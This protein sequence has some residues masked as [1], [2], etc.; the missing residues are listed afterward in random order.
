MDRFPARSF[1]KEHRS[2]LTTDMIHL[3]RP[4]GVDIDGAVHVQPDAAAAA[5]AAATSGGGGAAY[6]A[7]G[8]L[9]NPR[10]STLTAAD[11]HNALAKDAASG[12]RTLLRVPLYYAGLSPGATVEVEWVVSV[13]A[14]DGLSVD[15]ARLA[16]KGRV[17]GGEGKLKLKLNDRSELLLPFPG[18]G[19]RPHSFAFFFVALAVNATVAA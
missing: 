6:R 3:L 12:R 8:H 11:T 15:Q 1:F 13:L 16:A 2:L 17:G 4:N 14:D 5:A 10:G 19:V 18:D 7:V 9:F